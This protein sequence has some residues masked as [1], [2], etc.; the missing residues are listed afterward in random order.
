MAI[1]PKITHFKYNKCYTK[2]IQIK[3][4]VNRWQQRKLLQ[5]KKQNLKD[6]YFLCVTP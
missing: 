4:E 5:R 2:E 6:K 1:P 3:K